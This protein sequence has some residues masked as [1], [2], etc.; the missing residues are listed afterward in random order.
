MLDKQWSGAGEA[1]GQLHA[2][3]M[4]CTLCRLHEER[5]HAVPGVG[6]C[7][8]GV[9][10]VGEAPGFFEDQQ[11]LPFVGN[12]GKLL[13][14]LLESAGLKRSEVFI[15]NVVK[16]RPPQNRDPEPDEISA[17][18]PYLDEQ[19]RLVSPKLIIVL[20]RH[21][22]ARLIPGSS[23]IKAVHGRVFRKQ[24]LVIF[25]TYHPAA[26]LRNAEV[27]EELKED[28]NNLRGI[29][30]SLLPGTQDLNDV[31][32]EGLRDSEGENLGQLE[33]F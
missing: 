13:T 7:P 27:F 15:T 16:C 32:R 30:G 23:G 12:A 22:L 11:G 33:L 25:P 9:M 19:I 21:A 8:A 10:V 24:G 6:P 28:F 4:G 29:I 17:C 5:T 1:L 14:S 18:A 3:I 20:G 2:K 31:E 26:A